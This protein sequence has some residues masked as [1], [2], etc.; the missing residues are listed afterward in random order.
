MN[1]NYLDKDFFLDEDGKDL[2]SLEGNEKT[3]HLC[4]TDAIETEVEI[5]APHLKDEIIKPTR[6]VVGLGTEIPIWR[7]NVTLK[8]KF[9][10][11]FNNYSNAENIKT[12]VR[13]ILGEALAKW[14]D[15]SPVQFSETNGTVDFEISIQPDQC[16]AYGCTL[17]SAFFPN[18]EQNTLILH[19]KMFQQS[20]F[21]QIETMIHELGHVFGL[22]HF[23]AQERESA[24][25]SEVFGHHVPLSIMNYGQSSTLTEQ[26]KIDLKKFYQLAWSGELSHLKGMPIMMYMPYT[27]QGQLIS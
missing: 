5:H 13:G 10:S 1:T 19:P 7:P 27:A 20:K 4:T 15:S 21:E 2:L 22:R 6:I 12:Y 3:Q 11:S 14:G 16:N 24:W 17:A 25:P 23:F 9:D 8:W 26:D 18:S